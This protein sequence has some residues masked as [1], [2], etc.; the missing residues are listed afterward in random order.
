[1]T[2]TPQG[3]IDHGDYDLSGVV[4]DS[5][6]A[7]LT[8]VESVDLS[9]RTRLDGWT[10]RDIVVHLGTW[11]G[12]SAMTE[13]VETLGADETAP[14]TDPDSLNAALIDAHGGASDD[15]VR[16]ALR[17]SRDAAVALLDS[18]VARQRGTE[19][20]VGVTG[21][22]PLLTVMH[23]GCYELALHALDIADAMEGEV[24]P[25]LLGH[26]IAALADST[27]CLAARS[28]A[29]ATVGVIADEAAWSFT[30]MADSGWTTEQVVGDPSGPRVS[31]SATDLLEASSGRQDPVRLVARRRLKVAHVGGLMALTP[32]LDSVPG[33]PGGKSLAFAAKSLGGVGSL[34][35][36]LR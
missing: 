35:G 6:D 33:L 15:D 2:S 9:A 7:F 13:V 36:R 1:M 20:V 21:A 32:V 5:W 17:G 23:A 27:G 4:R 16:D 14:H 19:L 10:V 11:D 12:R 31:G 24:D 28:S 30:S 26:G 22:M 29:E 25:A 18:D 3:L 8:Q 34:L